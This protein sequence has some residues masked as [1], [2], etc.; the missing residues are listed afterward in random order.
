VEN[1]FRFIRSEKNAGD[2]APLT[3]TGRKSSNDGRRNG[4][5]VSTSNRIRLRIQT[6]RFLETGG[7]HSGKI[8]RHCVC[9]RNF[10][11]RAERRADFSQLRAIFEAATKI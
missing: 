5:A 6:R 1:E 10:E 11:P 4:G 2:S 8:I 3:I 7:R 9:K